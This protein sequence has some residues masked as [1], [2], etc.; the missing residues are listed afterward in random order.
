MTEEPVTVYNFQVEDYHTHHVSGFGVLVHNASDLYA[1]GSFRRSARQKAE[2]EA[3]RNSNGKMKCPTCGKEIPDKI[4]INTKN[5]PVDRIGYDLDHYPETWAE[6]K[7]KLQSL[8]TTPTRTE[9]LDCYNSDLRV[10][11]HECNIKHI[12]EGVKGDFAE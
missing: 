5:G 11:C 10:Q 2:S 9:V 3:P 6:R 1:R 4:T 7:V 8:E 12:F